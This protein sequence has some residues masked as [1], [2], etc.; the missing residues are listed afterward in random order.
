M[1]GKEDMPPLESRRGGPLEEVIFLGLRGRDAE[2]QKTGPRIRSSSK[3]AILTRGRDYLKSP[4]KE[5]H[6]RKRCGDGGGGTPPQRKFVAALISWEKKRRK[7]VLTGK[8]KLGSA[9]KKTSLSSRKKEIS[10]ICKHRKRPSLFLQR[11]IE[12]TKVLLTSGPEKNSESRACRK[13]SAQKEISV[14]RKREGASEITNKQKKE[15]SDFL[16]RREES[17]LTLDRRGGI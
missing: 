12:K 3:H 13:F 9:G 6:P 10:L 2:D 1:G 14:F 11:R 7:L 17:P 8:R 5:D 16:V 4:P 15:G